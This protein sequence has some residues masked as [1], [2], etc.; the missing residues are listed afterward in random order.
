MHRQGNNCGKR[1]EIRNTTSHICTIREAFTEFHPVEEMINGVGDTG[2]AVTGRGTV[3]IKFEFDG[4][5]FIHQLRDTLYV[6][7]APNCLLSLSRIDDG[8]GSVDFSDGTCWIKDKGKK[9]IGKGYKHHR[10]FMLYARAALPGKE[11]ANYASTE[12]LTWD[13]WHRRYG[14]I[15]IS[16]LQTL[17]KEKMVN[18]LAIDQSSIPPKTCD[19]CIKAKQTHRPFPAE[20]ENRSQIPGEHFMTDVW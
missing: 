5:T 14:H 4:K 6:P 9:I 20:A 7:N 2:T 12:K 8:G 15:S 3:K 1:G 18:G 17:K 10:L 16:A 13:Q 19:A 11:T